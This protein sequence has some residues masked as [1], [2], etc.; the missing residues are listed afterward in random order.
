[1]TVVRHVLFVVWSVIRM[2]AS[3]RNLTIVV[4]VLLGLVIVA[5]TIAAQTA[6][7]FVLYPFA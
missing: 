3:T 5:V 1:M 4:G 2:G 7:P 6:A